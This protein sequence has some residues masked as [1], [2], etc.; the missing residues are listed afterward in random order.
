M[1]RARSR[2]P[3]ARLELE[4]TGTL[5]DCLEELNDSH[6]LTPAA[7]G[8]PLTPWQVGTRLEEANRGEPHDRHELYRPAVI[9]WSSRRGRPKII[10]RIMAPAPGGALELYTITKP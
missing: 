5:W 9:V 10:G 6:R 3:A 8:E 7:G 2:A 4:A 1:E